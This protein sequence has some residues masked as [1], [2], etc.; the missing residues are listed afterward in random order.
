M[1]PDELI[2]TGSKMQEWARTIAE[3]FLFNINAQNKFLKVSNKLS[4]LY[5]RQ[6]KALGYD[7]AHPR[8]RLDPPFKVLR[9]ALGL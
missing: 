3:E 2:R 1:V 7:L 4:G 8:M 9:L 6:I 5:M